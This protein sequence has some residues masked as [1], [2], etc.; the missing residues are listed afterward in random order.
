MD[1]VKPGTKL[2]TG[3]VYV[4]PEGEKVEGGLTR[5]KLIDYQ[6]AHEMYG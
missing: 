6:Q 4:D 5:A 3:R 1:V 2:Q